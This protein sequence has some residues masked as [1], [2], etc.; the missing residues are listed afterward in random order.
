MELKTVVRAGVSLV[1]TRDHLGEKKE[2]YLPRC[3]PEQ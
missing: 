1:E 2:T 3:I